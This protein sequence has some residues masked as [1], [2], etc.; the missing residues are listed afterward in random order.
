MLL[1]SRLLFPDIL[2][3]LLEAPGKLGAE[4]VVGST[5]RLGIPLGYGGP[6]AAYFATIDDYKRHV[7]GRIIG[8]TRN[9]DNPALRIALQTREQHIKES[10]HLKYLYNT[11]VTC[12][13]GRY[14]YR[15]SRTEKLHAIAQHTSMTVRLEKSLNKLGLFGLIPISLHLI[16]WGQ[17]NIVSLLH[18]ENSQY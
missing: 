3:L 2:S 6:H 7:P 11:S 16:Y 1:V 18:Y 4:V 10:S 14:V 13:D 12:C 17:K 5:Q 15:L 8:Q 9:I